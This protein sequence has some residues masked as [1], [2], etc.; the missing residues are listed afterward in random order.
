MAGG[1]GAAA[2]GLAGFLGLAVLGASWLGPAPSLAQR[3]F[4]VHMTLH[5]AVVAV[6]SGLLALAL[7]G[8]RWDPARRWPR[9]VS[10]IP[11]SFVELVV[12]WAWHAPALHRAA[13]NSD[14]A[15]SLEQASFLLS[16]LYLWAAA[17]GGGALQRRARAPA[18]ILAL[19][20]T[21][22]HM[23]L[24]GALLALARRPLYRHGGGDAQRA[25]G[26]DPLADQELG[27]AIMLLVGGA[28]YLAGGLWLT[29]ETLRGSGSGS[30]SGAGASAWTTQRG[31]EG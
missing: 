6:A 29:V 28:A 13:R 9:L 7:A 11:A 2:R 15:F 4:A 27:G 18:G 10:A 26:L 25:L 1:G 14:V 3:S 17:F 16:G 20:L 5:M 8:T 22:M 24:L 30:G 21:A 31:S 19:L 23:T 12:V